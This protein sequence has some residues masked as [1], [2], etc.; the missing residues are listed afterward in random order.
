MALQQAM[1]Q[2]EFQVGQ[3]HRGVKPDRLEPFG[4]KG[5]AAVAED[6]VVLAGEGGPFAAAQQGLDPHHQ[7]L[8]V[9]GLG[10]VVVGAGVEAAHLVLGAAEGCEHQ[11]RNLGGLFVATESLAD[12][13]PI[14]VGQHQIQ[15]DHIGSVLLGKGLALDAVIGALHIETAVLEVAR[16]QIAHVAVVLDEQDAGLH[17]GWDWG[18]DR[19]VTGATA[20]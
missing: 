10:E 12:G 2:F 14:D 6:L 5:E 16:H 20:A 18:R 1:Q 3:P 19:R 7:L 11:D 8:E 13:E 4:Q 15:Q 17:G 9:K